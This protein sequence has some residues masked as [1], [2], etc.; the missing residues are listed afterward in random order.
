MT[1]ATFVDSLRRLL[2]DLPQWFIERRCILCGN[3]R[4]RLCGACASAIHG[5]R[6]TCIGCARGTGDRNTCRSCR[7]VWHVER[8][9]AATDYARTGMAGLIKEYKYRMDRSLARTMGG[10]M[11]RAAAVHLPEHPLFVPVPLH[12]RRRR[13]RGFNHAELLA[14]ACAGRSLMHYADALARTRDSRPQARSGRAERLDAVRGAFAAHAGGAVHGR[15]V[16]LVDDVCTTGAT[17]DDCA[18]ALLDAGAGSVT[19]L[20]FARKSGA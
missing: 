12:P 3:G 14:R 11:L 1:A 17:L 15:N 13:W 9:I 5:A 16:V 6:T 20:V 19:G 4:N 18:R 10:I 8:L 2:A 7:N